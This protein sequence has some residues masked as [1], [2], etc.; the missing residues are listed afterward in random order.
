[1]FA[2]AP[3]LPLSEGIPADAVWDRGLTAVEGEIFQYD[4]KLKILNR[5]GSKIIDRFFNNNRK[6]PSLG[7]EI[8]RNYSLFISEAASLFIIH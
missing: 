8:H 5:S 6:F 2:H 4:L 1:M 7:E 3:C